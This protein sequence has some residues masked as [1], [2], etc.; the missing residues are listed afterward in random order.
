MGSLGRV[1][2]A[3]NRIGKDCNSSEVSVLAT[4]FR[5]EGR[6]NYAVGIDNFMKEYGLQ[7][8][9]G[10]SGGS[11]DKLSGITEDDPLQ[12]SFTV[13]RDALQERIITDALRALRNYRIAIL[14]GGTNWGV[15]RLAIHK[16]HDCGF[17]TIGVLPKVGEKYSLSEEDLDLR[18]VVEPII[19]G[20]FWGDEG[21][22]WT[23]MIDGMIIIG[24]GAGTLTECAHIMKINE[25]LVKKGV[26]P[27]YMVP[28]HGT[29]G[30]AE[31]LHQLWGKP[32]IRDLSM[33]R[34]R[35]HT[36][37]EAAH[38]LIEALDLDE[39]FD[40]NMS[41]GNMRLDRSTH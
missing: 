20:G 30:V 15:P 25:A 27:K 10:I 36:G 12:I 37:T 18:I 29:G 21:P 33:P 40:P 38:L 17:K 14:T 34:G 5:V 4:Q 13:F 39:A 19:G 9:I 2:L 7:R 24:G 41:S 23:S 16:A 8:I 35:V 22:I 11:D 31:Q 32:R 6:E 26:R 1:V 28:I 3:R